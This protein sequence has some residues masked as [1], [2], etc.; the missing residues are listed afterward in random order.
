VRLGQGRLSL[1]LD[2]LADAIPPALDTTRRWRIVD[3]DKEAQW[4]AFRSDS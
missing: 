3:D 4:Q 1:P 2:T